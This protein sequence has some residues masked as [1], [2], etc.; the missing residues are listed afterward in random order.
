MAGIR[1]K[2]CILLVLT[3]LVLL[4]FS[5]PA[6]AQV[7]EIHENDRIYYRLPD[8]SIAPE[9]W[10]LRGEKD[11]YYVSKE[12][13]PFR[14][15]VIA[16]YD[17]NY[18]VFDKNGV[19][20]RSQTIFKNGLSYVIDENGAAHPEESEEELLLQKHAASII[21]EI[22]NESMS[23]TDKCNAIYDYLWQGFTFDAA[24]DTNMDILQSGLKGFDLR[25]GNCFVILS[26]AH[27]LYQAIGVKDMLVIG[28]ENGNSIGHWWSM[29]KVGDRY[30]HV[31][32]TP[33]DGFHGWNL[34][35][36]EELFTSSKKTEMTAYEHQFDE[37]N[38]PK[39]YDWEEIQ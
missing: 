21:A 5:L 38:Y 25:R 28:A 29:V 37:S 22:T 3:L 35:T 12:G 6:M 31:D 36:T 11:W 13:E 30:Y 27:Y 39:S 8:G 24:N 34:V 32:A 1:R 10:E 2:I 26:K 17:D 14:D 15:T 4:C 19:M 33:F 16:A 7:E 23:L 9:Y 18:Y 20:L